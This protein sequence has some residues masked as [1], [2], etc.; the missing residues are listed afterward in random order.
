VQQ[1]VCPACNAPLRDGLC[2]TSILR[3]SNSGRVPKAFNIKATGKVGMM[4]LTPLIE[5]SRRSDVPPPRKTTPFQNEAPSARNNADT[6]R[7]PP[8]DETPSVLA[9]EEE[10]AFSPEPVYI[11]PPSPLPMIAG[12]SFDL[13]D[14]AP[15]PWGLQ[16]SD[17]SSNLR[18]SRFT[19]VYAKKLAPYAFAVCLAVVFIGWLLGYKLRIESQSARASTRTNDSTEVPSAAPP[20]VSASASALPSAETVP[21]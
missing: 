1:N 11:P 12:H 17:R 16:T 6:F 8:M 21:R 9:M 2:A 13:P 4:R 20:V 10:A 5:R 15:S 14:S 19:M 7:P 18:P 3:C